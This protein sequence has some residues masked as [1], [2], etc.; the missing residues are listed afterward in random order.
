MSAADQQNEIEQIR[1]F[2]D[3]EYYGRKGLSRRLPWHCRRA[4][5]LL[6][7]VR[8]RAVLDVA[9]GLG[10]WLG[11]FRDRGASGI[12]GIDLSARA[13]EACRASYPS[14]DFKVG[15]A[16]T[17]PFADASFDIVT[18]M[19]SLEHFVDK[20][21]ALREMLRVARPG[22]RFVLLVPNSGFLTRRLGL[23]SGTQQAKI[24]EDV[25]SLNAWGALFN[26]SGLRV[27][28]R[29]RDLHPLSVS[30]ITMGKPLNWPVRALQALALT[31]WPL[32]WQYQVYHF[33]ERS[34]P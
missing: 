31:L 15:E 20:P 6:G 4:A 27:T 16:E 22:A 5:G 25:Q 3:E 8:G 7:D 24:K 29:L 11:Y 23:Y 28:R 1:K 34:A 12:S 10:D 13:I 30:W 33:C 14:G 18:C 17:L 21:A 26:A 2:Y 9:C 19:G 32:S